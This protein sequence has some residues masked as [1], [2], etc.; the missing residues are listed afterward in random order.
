MFTRNYDRLLASMACGGPLPP[1]TTTNGTTA[2]FANK[3]CY[4]NCMFHYINSMGTSYSSNGVLFGTGITPPQKSDYRLSGSII[5]TLA[6]TNTFSQFVDDA[7]AGIEFVYTL[8]NTGTSEVT[9]G[10][11]GYIE[12]FG[13]RERYLTA[14][15]GRP[16]SFNSN[17]AGLGSFGYFMMYREVLDTP[18]TIPA[19]GVG[20]V[21][22]S[23]RS[24]IPTT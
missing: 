11:V 7:G 13:G 15:N 18:V 6:H 5:T 12:A 3:Y 4:G 1:L 23:I 14:T 17:T 22:L 16:G 2:T 24:N 10:E 19:G 21:K 8:T 20:Q 9:I